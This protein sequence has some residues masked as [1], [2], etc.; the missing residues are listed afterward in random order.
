MEDEY[1]LPHNL[2]TNRTYTHF[3]AAW[4]KQM[5]AAPLTAKVSSSPS[6][7]SACPGVC[8]PRA[9]SPATGMPA[10]EGPDTLH[11]F[12]AHGMRARLNAWRLLVAGAEKNA[13]GTGRQGGASS[14]APA[15]QAALVL[16]FVVCGHA[17]CAG[18]LVSLH[19]PGL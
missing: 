2:K 11:G 13:A 14:V 3:W 8:C 7:R 6:P 10:T 4:T 16:A 18:M 19:V 17:R 12:V 15:V 1:A 5:E 9:S